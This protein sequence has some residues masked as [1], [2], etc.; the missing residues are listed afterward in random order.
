[1]DDTSSV[2]PLEVV[3]YGFAE[4]RAGGPEPNLKKKKSQSTI[5]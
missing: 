5:R 3:G 4:S 1:M 2:R